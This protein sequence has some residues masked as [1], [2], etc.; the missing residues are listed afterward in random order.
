MNGVDTQ[1][2]G[3]IQLAMELQN[4]LAA[5][6]DE[7]LLSRSLKDPALFEMLVVRY[8]RIFFEKALY[9]LKSKDDAEDAV[10]DAFVRVYRF[11]P[12]FRGDAGS[13]RSWSV[14]VLMNVVR[15]RYQKKSTEWTRHAP[16]TPEHYETLAAPSEKNAIQAR[17][18]IVRAFAHVPKDV[19]RIL[20]L[21]CIQELPYEEIA[22]MEGISVGAVKTRVH[23]AKKVL[24]KT[25]GDIRI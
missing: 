20:E 4:N 3:G 14:T 19:A 5:L 21:A 22:R 9:V 12:Q 1:S 25:I 24:R 8:Q 23:R 10:Q 2:V 15:T 11:A 7:E 16:L 18:I 6:S 17:D 13:F